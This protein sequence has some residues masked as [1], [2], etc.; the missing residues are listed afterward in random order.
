M[1]QL[2]DMNGYSDKREVIVQVISFGDIILEEDLPYLFNEF[3]ERI[4]LPQAH[5]GRSPAVGGR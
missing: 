2:V 5:E 1:G 3:L 4:L